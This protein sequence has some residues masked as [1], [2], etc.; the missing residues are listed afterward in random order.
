MERE[1]EKRRRGAMAFEVNHDGSLRRGEERRVSD[2]FTLFC[3]RV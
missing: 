2:L 3:T 1:G